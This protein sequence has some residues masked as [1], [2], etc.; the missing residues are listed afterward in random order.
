MVGTVILIVLILLLVGGLAP[1]PGPA[2]P[3]GPPYHGYGF[4]W[5]VG[6][7][8]LGVL[9]LVILILALLGHL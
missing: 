1:W 5:P 2:A 6:G 4:G 7:G 3:G 8:L 9:L